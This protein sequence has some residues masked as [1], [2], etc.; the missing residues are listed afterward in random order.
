[1]TEYGLGRV[2]PEIVL[3]DDFTKFCHRRGVVLSVLY[4]VAATGGH[5]DAPPIP[6][7]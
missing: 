2:K 5:T 4:E 7:S 1:M 3:P 6:R